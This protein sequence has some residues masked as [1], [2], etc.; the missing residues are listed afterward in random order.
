VSSRSATNAATS[1]PGA[2]EPAPEESWDRDALVSAQPCL[3]ALSDGEEPSLRAARL[4]GRI[5]ADN[6]WKPPAGTYVLLLDADERG[7]R[8]ALAV[9]RVATEA[10]A[11]SRDSF[12]VLSDDGAVTTA[13]EATTDFPLA[14]AAVFLDNGN[15]LWLRRRETQ[16]SIETTLGLT[17]ARTGEITPVAL[18]GA[19]PKHR[20]VASLVP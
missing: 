17:D 2:P 8:V 13:S 16:S 10:P 4:D 12:V 9:S 7:P 5:V 3:V 20:F 19:W 1:T 6:L 18:S 11:A 14:S 15:L